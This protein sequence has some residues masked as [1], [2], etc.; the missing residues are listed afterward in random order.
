MKALIPGS[1][2]PITLGHVNIIERTAAMFDSVTVAVMNNDSAK[3]DKSLSSKSYMFDMDTRMEIAKLSLSH[4]NNV[5]V[6]SYSGMLIDLFDIT[7][8][9]VI[10]K[11]IRN[12]N[13]L[14]Y[15]KKH[16]SWNK[17]HNPA[18][19][20]LFL[21]ADDD[22]VSVSSTLVRSMIESGDY[23]GLEGIIATKAIN[24][25]KNGKI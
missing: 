16:A 11:G 15:E 20:T 5:E 22:L 21:P 23:D 10:V 12:G 1:F 17:A 4:L 7:G 14:D 2:D 18:A 6:I 19:E 3:Y 24:Y 13:D 25:L 9:S 8:A